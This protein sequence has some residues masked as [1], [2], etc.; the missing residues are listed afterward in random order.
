MLLF[1]QHKLWMYDLRAGKRPQIE[2]EWGDARVTALVA[3]PDGGFVGVVLGGGSSGVWVAWFGWQ[4]LPWQEM[5]L[6]GGSSCDDFNSTLTRCLRMEAA[7]VFH[8]KLLAGQRVWAANGSG[9][10]EGVDMRARAMRGCLKQV[11]TLEQH[12]RWSHA[13]SARIEGKKLHSAG[14]N[15]CN[16][17][18]TQIHN[19]VIGI[20]GTA[21]ALLLLA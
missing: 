9:R 1:L 7:S 21:A 18:N 4:A 8:G 10:I 15:A 6:M 2:I 17:E 3:D 5:L 11:L 19:T 12:S 14:A 13:G 20:M 16:H